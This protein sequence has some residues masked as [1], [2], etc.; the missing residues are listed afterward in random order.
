MSLTQSQ[1]DNY[2]NI[3]NKEV[4]ASEI[5]NLLK[6][7][8]EDNKDKIKLSGTKESL[9]ENLLSA[10]T[11]N[12]IDIVDIQSLI[13]DSEEFGDQ[14]IFLFELTNSAKKTHYDNGNAIKDV[15]TPVALRNQF[16]R[17]VHQP[18]GREWSDFRINYRGV[19]NSW[20]AKLYDRKIRET[21]S[22]DYID[23]VTGQRVIQM[24]NEEFRM[25][26]IA[27]W[28]GDND[29]EIKFT[30]TS[31]ESHKSI[32]TT[33]AIIKNEVHGQGRG[34]QLDSDFRKKDLRRNIQN[35]ISNQATNTGIYTLISANFVDSEGG[36]TLIKT[37]DDRGTSDL[38]AESSR[39]GAIDSFMSGDGHAGGVVIRLLAAGSNN[40]LSKDLNV[41]I[42]RDDYNHIVISSKIKPQ[43][44]RYVRRKIEEFS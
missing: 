9:I 31:S 17:F 13:K 3:L 40:I 33:M 30:R 7:H 36:I 32:R 12:I 24:R 25:I 21:K 19:Q 26:Y 4:L 15:I 38:L 20:M 44:Y 43:E 28:D 11:E 10:A 34:L 42:G 2:Y 27:E 37:K 16:P 8:K 5:Y 14:N 22:D 39:K 6:L 18:S 23:Q 41:A 29:V 35:L 1:R